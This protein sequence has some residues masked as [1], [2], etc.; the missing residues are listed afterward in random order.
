MVLLYSLDDPQHPIGT[1]QNGIGLMG[2]GK[3]VAWLDDQGEKAVILA[4]SYTYSNYQWISSFVH[5][6]DIQLDGFSD[7]TQPILIYPNSQQITFPWMRPPFIRLVCSPFGHLAIFDDL[8]IPGI[9]YSAPAGTYPNTNSRYFTSNTVSCIRGTY[10]NYTGIELCMP[11]SNGTYTY[12]SNCSLCTS[13]NSFCPYGAVEE[14]SYSTFESIEQDQDY[15]ESP[16]NTVFD[17]ILMQNMFSFNLRFAHCA[18][19]SPITWVL[20]VVGLGV[21]I[22]ISMVIHEL[23]IGGLASAAVIVIT[24]SAYSFSNQYFHQYP[25]EQVTSDSSFACDVTLRNAKFST[26]IQMTSSSRNTTKQNQAIFNM[27]H[28]QSFTLNIDLIQTAF[29]CNDSLIVQ[30]LVGSRPAQLPIS[31]CQTSYNGSILS[32]AIV[33]PTQEIGIQFTLPGS[34]TIGA[35]RLGLSGPSAVSTDK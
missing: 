5:I 18:L 33:L 30:R 14:I 29:T 20:L 8:G 17:D 28:S 34:R 1:R 26:T 11:C 19:V 23:W 32:L 25:I 4:N 35:I 24:I 31:V 12:S 10:R 27:L 7:S 6:Y 9:I 15:P 16:E 21:I 13:P 22:A 2:F 3:S